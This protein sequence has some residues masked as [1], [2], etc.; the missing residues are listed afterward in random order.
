MFAGNFGARMG[1]LYEGSV[2]SLGS[3]QATKLSLPACLLHRRMRKFAAGS[4]GGRLYYPIGRRERGVG[5]TNSN[6]R[7]LQ[8]NI[9]TTIGT[10]IL[11]LINKNKRSVLDPHYGFRTVSTRCSSLCAHCM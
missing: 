4:T 3:A 11:L 6:S 5:V 8:Y 9:S 7:V 2:L 1:I 10:W